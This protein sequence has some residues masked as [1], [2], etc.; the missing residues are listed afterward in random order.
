[1][2]ILWIQHCWFHGSD[3]RSP[4]FALFIVAAVPDLMDGH[5]ELLVMKAEAKIGWLVKNGLFMVQDGQA[6]V[7]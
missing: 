2:G 1:M 4:R 6:L 7:G 5:W 3:H